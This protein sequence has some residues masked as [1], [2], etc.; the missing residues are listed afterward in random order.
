MINFSPNVDM[1]IPSICL[2]LPHHLSPFTV[3]PYFSAKDILGLS[4]TFPPPTPIL[5]LLASIN[6]LQGNLVPIIEE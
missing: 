1:K 3:V 2:L 5:Y 4:C 6:F